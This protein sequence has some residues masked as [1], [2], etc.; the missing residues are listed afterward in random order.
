MKKKWILKKL[1][2][3]FEDAIPSADRRTKMP[4]LNFVCGIVFC[5]LGDSKSFSLEALRRSLM[6]IFNIKINRSSFWQRLSGRRLNSILRDLIARLIADLQC[7]SVLGVDLLKKLGVNALYLIDSSSNTLW[8]GAGEDFPGTRTNA[9]IKWHTMID[10][11]TG[12]VNWFKLTATSVN[13]RKCFP[14]VSSL[15]GAL[16]IFDLGYWDYSLLIDIA[17]AQGF[18]LSRVKINAAVTVKEVV[19][20]ISTSHAGKRLSQLLFKKRVSGIVELLVDINSN[21][22]TR[23]FRV[24]GFWNPVEKKYHWYITNLTVSAS[25]IYTLY[26]IRWQLELFFKGAKRSFNLDGKIKSNNKNIIESLVLT[27]VIASMAAVVVLEIGRNVLSEERQAAVSFQRISMVTVLLA[28]HFID[29][30]VSASGHYL[31]AL[32]RHIK[33]LSDE[34]YEKNYQRRQTS[35]QRLVKEL[36]K[37]R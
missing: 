28:R 20:G 1:R 19:S 8:D 15:A 25:V 23:E 22:I 32:I 11:I 26:K 13:D 35:M 21:G 4:H 5:F 36:G 10:L 9:G 7:S 2:K 3:C 6:S 37:A 29:Y 31:D 30:L 17:L 16:I 14:D 27:T 33:F 12:K 34:I 18:F 24:I